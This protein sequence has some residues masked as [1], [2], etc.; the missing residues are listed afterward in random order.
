MAPRTIGCAARKRRLAAFKNRLLGTA[1]ALVALVLPSPV[2]AAIPLCVEVRGPASEL[3]G[4][5]KLVKN[6]LARHPSHATVVTDCRSSL[7]VELFDV[8]GARYLDGSDRQRGSCA[9]RHPRGGGARGP[10]ERCGPGCSPQRPGLPRGGRYYL[11]S[12]S[13]WA[14]AS[15]SGV[16][17]CFVLRP[18]NDYLRRQ[19]RCFSARGWTRDDA[20]FRKLAG[21]RSALRRSQTPAK[22]GARTKHAPRSRVRGRP[23][24]RSSGKALPLPTSRLGSGCSISSSRGVGAPPI[25]RPPTRAS[26]VSP[27]RFAQVRASSGGTASISTS[28][29]QGYLPVSSATDVDGVLFGQAGAYTPSVQLGLGVGF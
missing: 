14:A 22:R 18:S 5:R 15:R 8:G 1:L 20:R 16:G 26:R 2:C 29:V 4:L 17:G 25:A 23:Q 7:D 24:L 11:N 9:V 12:S 19:R 10:G 3:P 27:S 13:A 28:S 21:V 6:E